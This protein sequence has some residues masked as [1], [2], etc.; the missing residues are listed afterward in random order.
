MYGILFFPLISGKVE[1]CP[2]KKYIEVLTPITS[3]DDFIL[4]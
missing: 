4:R 2:I 1:F 3:E